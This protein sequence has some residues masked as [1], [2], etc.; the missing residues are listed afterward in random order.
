M[1]HDRVQGARELIG[2]AAE[3]ELAAARRSSG[4]PETPASSPAAELSVERICECFWLVENKLSLLSWKVHGVFPWPFIRMQLF[5]LATRTAGLYD[6]PHPAVDRKSSKYRGAPS[7]ESYWNWQEKKHALKTRLPALSALKDRFFKRPPYAILMATRKTNGSELYTDALRTELGG[8]AILLDRAIGGSVHEGAFDFDRLVDVFQSRY[9][10]VEHAAMPD[11]DRHLCEQIGTE[12][13]RL[14]GVDLGDIGKICQ[15]RLPNFIAVRTGFEKFFALNPVDTLFLTNAYGISTKAALGG[16]RANGARI[17]ELQHGNISKFHLGYSWPGRP[18]V[19]DS[20]DELW[21]FGDFWHETTPLPAGTHARTIGAPY[22]HAFAEAA[23]APR[24]ERLVVFTS[25][26][27][28]GR[29]LFDMAVETARRRPDFRIV[30]R[31]HPSEALADYEAALRE[32]GDVPAN[33]ELS[34]RS[35]NIFALL[36]TAAIQVG[37]F[38]TTLFEGMSLGTRTIVVDLPGVEYMRPAI[39][40]GDVLFVRNAAE[41]SEKLDRAPLARDPEYYYA[42]PLTRLV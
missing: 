24:D 34:H 35:P 41:L 11:S 10:Q 39:E 37:A 23:G 18:E 4:I 20:P 6:N 26:G 21:C 12:F 15:R 32:Q 38:S 36:A 17:V 14:L 42:K 13:L 29:S 16:A 2:R 27:V 3:S 8:R 22:V 7:L 40:K 33:F 9:R 5:Y 30:F 28:I 31:L 1:A 19:P 25:Q